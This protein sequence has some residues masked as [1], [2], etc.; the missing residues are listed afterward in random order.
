MR[1]RGYIYG[2]LKKTFGY[3]VLY[4]EL[5]TGKEIVKPKHKLGGWHHEKEKPEGAVFGLK[6]ALGILTDPELLK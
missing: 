2:S 1:S 3:C 4:S 5:G 6:M